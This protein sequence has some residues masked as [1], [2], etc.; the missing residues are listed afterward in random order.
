MKTLSPFRPTLL[1]SILVPLIGW[2]VSAAPGQDS[3]R[4]RPSINQSAT[5]AYQPP[6][7]VSPRLGDIQSADEESAAV[8]SRA[9]EDREFSAFHERLKDKDV[10]GMSPQELGGFEHILERLTTSLTRQYA[11]ATDQAQRKELESRLAEVVN[12]HFAVR[13]AIRDREIAELEKEVASLRER[14]QQ[15]ED[16]K[17]QITEGRVDQLLRSARGLGWDGNT[18]RLQSP[19]A[20]PAAIGSR[21]PSASPPETPAIQLRGAPDPFSPVPRPR[22]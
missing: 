15:R 11:N 5:T 22:S 13:H 9:I 1:L 10:A 18:S 19:V 8:Y 4:S 17:Q 6:D 7:A 21:L 16:A 12:K 14:L 20:R 2:Q 3:D